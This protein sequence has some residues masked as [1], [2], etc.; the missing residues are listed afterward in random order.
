[1]NENEDKVFATYLLDLIKKEIKKEM[2]NISFMNTY[3]GTVVGIGIDT[4]DIK[5]AG[6]DVILTGLKNKI[7]TDVVVNINDEVVVVV[8]KNN[9][10]NCFV[11]WVK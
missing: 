5:L 2:K 6:S 1:M 9:L 8:L 7:D 11:A 3:S 10:T 4:L